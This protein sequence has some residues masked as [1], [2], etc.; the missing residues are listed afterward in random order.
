MK[1]RNR[2]LS[3]ALTL[4]L[5]L[6]V[7]GCGD[8][9]SV[10]I[11]RQEGGEE[12]D[13]SSSYSGIEQYS[14][15]TIKFATW[16]DHKS[17][18]GAVPMASFADKYNI[19]IELSL[20]PQTDYSTRLSGM[21]ASGQSPDL[22]V[23]NNEFPYLLPCAEPLNNVAS[24]DLSDEFWDKSVT[25]MSTFNGNTYFVNSVNSPWTYRFMCFYNILF[26]L[27]LNCF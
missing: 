7:C 5:C 19:E 9:D 18:E 24:I 1:K 6:A 2:I 23:D 21:I 15:T 13:N 17:G 11:T 22:I 3:F 25:E 14:G 27:F 10:T 16:V 4:M 12:E 8:G 20:V 26:H